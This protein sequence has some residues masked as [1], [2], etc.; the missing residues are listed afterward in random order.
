MKRK[1]GVIPLSTGVIT[2]SDPTWDTTQK[3]LD[4][5]TEN[6]IILIFFVRI[7]TEK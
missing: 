6:I 2:D 3:G 4:Y 1:K 5:K 7:V